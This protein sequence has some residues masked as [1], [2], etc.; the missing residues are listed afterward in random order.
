MLALSGA[1]SYSGVTN[2]NS[3]TLEIRNA[4]ALG[5]VAGNTIVAAGARVFAGASFAGLTTAE[6]FN[7][8]GAGVSAGAIHVGGSAIGVGFTGAITLSGNTTIQG[9]GNTGTTFSGGIDLGANTLTLGVGG[10]ANTT[11]NTTGIS[12]TGSVI[13]DSLT[14]TLNFN[15]ANS[16]SGTTTI[17]GGVMSLGHVNALGGT[18]GITLSGGTTLTTQMDGIVIAAPITLGAAA[19]TTTVSFSRNISAEGTLTLN[20]AISGAG[21][22][23]FTTPNERQKAF[24][25][26]LRLAATMR[27]AVFG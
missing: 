18:S 12:G 5:T 3:G 19:T 10:N 4:S 25:R 6:P 16:Y 11:I 14:G 24:G 26:M 15:A 1:N 9:D 22:L 2:V 20:S 7:I 23:A 17:D 13:K 8:A 27:P 21:N